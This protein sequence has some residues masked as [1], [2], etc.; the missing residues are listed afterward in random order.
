MNALAR[1]HLLRRA[2]VNSYH[3]FVLRR[4]RGETASARTYLIDT[5]HNWVNTAT[6]LSS[7]SSSSSNRVVKG[8]VAFTHLFI[9]QKDADC[10]AKADTNNLNHQPQ[11]YVDAL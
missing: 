3:L 7:S 9:T 5:R 1:L 2:A 4:A 6:L 8:G 11:N 10:T